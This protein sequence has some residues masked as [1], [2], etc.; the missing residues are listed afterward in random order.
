MKESKHVRRFREQR[1]EPGERILAHVEGYIGKMMA[2]FGRDMQRNGALIVTDRRV[3]FY[4]KGLVGEA[5]ER[6]PVEKLTSIEERS[7]LGHRT[8]RLHTS[9]DHLEFKTVAAQ[10]RVRSVVS[11]L[12][13]MTRPGP[14]A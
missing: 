11:L 2:G 13:G 5:F 8:I 14:G 10:S 7:T 9:H 6:I 12:E 4:R 1:L 3:A